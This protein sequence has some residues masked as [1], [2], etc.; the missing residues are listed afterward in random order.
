M[1]IDTNQMISITEASQNFSSVT[2][3]V[4]KEGKAIIMKN[5]KP[6]YVILDFSVLEKNEIASDEALES[7]SERLLKKNAKAYKELAK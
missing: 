5:N 3:L 6:R 1:T 4:G 7:V 2:K